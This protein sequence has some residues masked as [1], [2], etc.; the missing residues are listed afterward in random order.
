MFIYNKYTAEQ[1]KWDQFYVVLIS[2]HN[3]CC[4][5]A[6][7]QKPQNISIQVINYFNYFEKFLSKKTQQS[8]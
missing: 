8:F 7:C 2:V 4:F 5:E 1:N 3:K 6:V